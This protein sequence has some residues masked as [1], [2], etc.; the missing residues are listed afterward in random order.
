MPR[1]SYKKISD[2]DKACILKCF[3]EGKAEIEK[4]LAENR[5]RF[6]SSTVNDLM[7]RTLQEYRSDSL[8][9]L[10]ESTKG[11]LGMV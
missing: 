8:K 7:E 6:V 11:M 4:K 10:T 2:E 3:N 9:E 5:T 1:G